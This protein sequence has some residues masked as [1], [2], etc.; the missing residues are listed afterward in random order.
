MM[1][2]GIVGADTPPKT[3]VLYHG[4]G[5][6]A[7]TVSVDPAAAFVQSLSPTLAFAPPVDFPAHCAV[8]SFVL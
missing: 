7:T 1:P 4:F 6:V 3:D 8:F 5:F 2:S